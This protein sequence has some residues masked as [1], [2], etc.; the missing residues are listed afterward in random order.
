[1]NMTQVLEPNFPFT[2][3][4]VLDKKHAQKKNDYLLKKLSVSSLTL[5]PMSYYD[6]QSQRRMDFNLVSG[7]DCF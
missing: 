6:A 7:R 2:N 4:R 5:Q 3:M 1:M